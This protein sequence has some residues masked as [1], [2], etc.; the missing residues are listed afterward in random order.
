MSEMMGTQISDAELTAFADGNLDPARSADVLEFMAR[1]PHEA[2]VMARSMRFRGEVGRQIISATPPV[3][4]SLRDRLRVV[5]EKDAA[6]EAARA[7]PPWRAR[8][9]AWL[10]LAAAALFFIAVGLSFG[11][12]MFGSSLRS[13]PAPASV[14]AAVTHIHVDC[15]RAPSLH[16]APFPHELGELSDQLK[17][18]LGKPNPWPDLSP[19]GLQY[20]GAGP[21]SAPMQG[22]VHLLYK[23]TRAFYTDTVSLF[24]QPYRGQISAVEGKLYWAAGIDSPH[25][26]LVWR[27]SGLVFYLVGD[28]SH[29]V[30][31]AAQFM[32]LHVPL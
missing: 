32:H 8:S 22:T 2:R 26:M 13:T 7:L 28:G 14:V 24:V 1:R 12:L 18:Y 21:C 5:V 6:D 16:H 4:Q 23:S 31:A 17:Q 20:I 27:Q 3:S 25:P 11:R 30:V 9:Q 19:I 10:G 15:S 29:E